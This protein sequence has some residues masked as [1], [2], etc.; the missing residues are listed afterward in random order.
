MVQDWYDGRLSANS[1]PLY[2]RTSE[3]L[4]WDPTD[5]D[6]INKTIVPYEEI[7]IPDTV[8][9]NTMD[10]AFYSSFRCSTTARA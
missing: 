4:D 10:I 6:M 2:K 3:F 5:Y 8:S 1:L 7:W 9:Y